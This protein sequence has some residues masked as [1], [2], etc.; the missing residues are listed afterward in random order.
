MNNRK[1]QKIRPKIKS[2]SVITI[3][4]IASYLLILYLRRCF[5]GE[6]IPNPIPFTI[7][8]IEFRWYGLI[9]TFGLA[10]AYYFSRQEALKNKISEDKFEI[11][12]FT[13]IVFGLIGARIGFVIQNTG[14]FAHNIGQIFQL[15]QGGMS[16]HGGIITGIIA[17]FFAT[18]KHKINF[19]NFANL[20][21]PYLFLASAIGRFGNF[22]NSEII[23][24]PTNLPWKM[25]VASDF[26]PSEFANSQ[27]FHPVFLYESILL[28]LSFI[29][30][31]KIKAKA[32]VQLGFAY[33][34]IVYNS[35]RVF[36]EFFRVDWHPLLLRL[37]LAQLVSLGLIIIGFMIYPKLRT[38]AKVIQQSESQDKV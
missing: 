14:F 9:I 28:F 13:I 21:A 30:Y 12:F 38:T 31:Q 1:K 6:I 22:F 26:R 10:L 35:I 15:W 18:R 24:R 29:V 2:Y 33:T 37:D 5:T 7:F 32:G 17:A 19:L 34:L 16:I 27:Y 3:L 11:I 20:V 23:G 8:G 36:V 25:L 4:L